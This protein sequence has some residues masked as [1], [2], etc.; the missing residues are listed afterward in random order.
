MEKEKLRKMLEQLHLELQGV[1][2][3]DEIGQKHLQILKQD[4][5]NLLDKSGEQPSGHSL[6][7]RLKTAIMDLEK[8]HPALAL[9]MKKL[10]D[11]LSNMGI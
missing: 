7:E 1:K 10:I 9:T 5:Q 8:S 11:T 6:I 2:S 4:I 3:A